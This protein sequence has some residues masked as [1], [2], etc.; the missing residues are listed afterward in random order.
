[1]NGLKILGKYGFLMLEIGK[2]GPELSK[3]KFNAIVF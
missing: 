2:C 1:V 3:R